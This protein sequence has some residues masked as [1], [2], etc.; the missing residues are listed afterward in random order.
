MKKYQ[1][2][3]SPSK[4]DRNRSKERRHI[5]TVLD[6]VIKKRSMAEPF[7][8]Y[9]TRLA[10]HRICGDAGCRF[11]APLEFCGNTLVVEVSDTVWSQE[12]QYAKQH[13]L[14]SLRME[15]PKGTAPENLRFVIRQPGRRKPEWEH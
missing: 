12:L 5:S 11:S 6:D 13:L 8:I 15:M 9:V 4:K 10:W 3:A 2:M 14:D 1:P 7:R